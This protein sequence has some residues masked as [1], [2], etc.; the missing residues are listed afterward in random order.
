MRFR[1]SEP[2]EAD[3]EEIFLYWAERVSEAVASRVIDQIVD[4]FRLIGEFPATGRHVPEAANDV[5]CFPAG[6]HLIYYRCDAD[7][8]EILHIFHAARDQKQA[9]ASRP[10]PR[11]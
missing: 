9:F 11:S 1:I 6:K 2:A 7:A 5:R 4:R 8:T 10:K 3:L